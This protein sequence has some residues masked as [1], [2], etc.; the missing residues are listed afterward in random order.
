MS[1]Q[2]ISELRQEADA[3]RNAIARD[4][5]LVTDRV[6]PGRIAD[7]QKARLNQRISG[8]RDTVFGT[9]DRNRFANTGS[10]DDSGT[11]ITD[12]AGNAIQHAKEAIPDPVGEFTEGNPLAAGLVGL[13]VGLLAASLIP[14]TP[15]EQK[16][17]DRAQDSIDSAAKQL[18]QSGQQA[19]EAI[20][21][22]A[23]DAA[24]EVK[25]SAQ[26]SVESVKSD[27][28]DAADTVKD[29]AQ[30]KAEDVR[31]EY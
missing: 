13:G 21:P 17:A 19:A 12:K 25:A 14:T 7:R 22:A 8:V 1:D 26:G 24:A 11:S 27:A 6:A 28:K 29:T 30:S 3:R 5:E 10:D 16:V 9:S 2:S 18:A 23:E 31:S 20:K 15:E 4:V